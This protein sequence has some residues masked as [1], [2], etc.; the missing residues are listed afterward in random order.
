[1][2]DQFLHREVEEIK[3]VM[4]IS[5]TR[6]YGY[7]IRKCCGFRKVTTKTTFALRPKVDFSRKSLLR[8]PFKTCRQIE[9]GT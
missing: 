4:E 6:L 8:R 7:W 2:E 3:A 5:A 9:G 1:M